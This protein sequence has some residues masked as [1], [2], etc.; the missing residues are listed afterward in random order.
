MANIY[1]QY[2]T[3]RGGIGNINRSRSR[4]PTSSINRSRSRNPAEVHSS[5]RGGAGNIHPGDGIIAETI[6]EKERRYFSTNQDG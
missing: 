3:G 5:G 6:D 4:D 1:R 2:S